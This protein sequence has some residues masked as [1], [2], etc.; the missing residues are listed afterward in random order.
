MGTYLCITD[1]HST[2]ICIA[3]YKQ[4]SIL[5]KVHSIFVLTPFC[6]AP[7]LLVD[8]FKIY[9]QANSILNIMLR[10]TAVYSVFILHT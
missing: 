7:A 10:Y 5:R 3:R 9:K 8:F 6:P 4:L 2:A 1:M